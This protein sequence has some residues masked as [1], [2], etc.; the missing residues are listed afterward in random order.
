MLFNLYAVQD[1]KAAAF[2]L[3]FV[4]QNEALAVRAFLAARTDPASEISKYPEDFALYFLGQYNQET[5]HI[6]PV[7][8]VVVPLEI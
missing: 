8:P 5:G 4:M 1:R 2:G 3:P 6:V 7:N